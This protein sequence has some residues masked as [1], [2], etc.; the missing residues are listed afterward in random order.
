MYLQLGT[1]SRFPNNRSANTNV[2]IFNP[3]RG[4]NPR[5]PALGVSR[6]ILFNYFKLKPYK[7]FINKSVNQ[8]LVFQLS[9]TSTVLRLLRLWFVWQIVLR[10]LRLSL[11]WQIVLRLL[12]LSLVWQ[13]VLRLLRLL[14]VWQIVLRHLRLSLVWQLV[15]RLLRLSLVWQIILRLLRLSLVWQIQT[16]SVSVAIRYKVMSPVHRYWR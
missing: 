14:L 3:T 5:S 6:L 15:L 10:L 16:I 7:W 13:I 8:C 4:P 1:L 11:V 2:I 9:C 12:R